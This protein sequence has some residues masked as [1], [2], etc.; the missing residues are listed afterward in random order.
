ML[1]ASGQRI[2]KL[3]AALMAEIGKL[4]SKPIPPAELDK[5]K[6]VL[7][8]ELLAKRETNEG[9]AYAL[10]DAWIGTGS[11]KTANT[12]LESL[13]A[14]T[15]ADVQRGDQD[16]ADRWQASES[17][18][19][20]RDDRRIRRQA[21]SRHP[22]QRLIVLLGFGLLTACGHSEAPAVSGDNSQLPAP[23]PTRA[24][25][26]A[27]PIEKQLANGLR[28]VVLPRAGSALVAAE[29]LLLSGSEVDPA[30]RAGLA[31]FTASLLTQ[32]HEIYN[33]QPQRQSACR[34]CRSA[35]RAAAGAGRLGC[36]DGRHHRDHTE[37]GR[38]ARSAGR[39]RP[40]SGRSRRMRWNAIAPRRSTACA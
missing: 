25:E 23:G 1:L 31:D 6:T 9:R 16:A 15:A 22:A 5:A 20:T 38:C 17:R 11:A 26:I 14:V 13:L 2:A 28:V 36:D 37:A 30:D 27:A 32:G 3:E 8:T 24:A 40:S 18:I 19:P 35:G 21:M 4:A 33:G 12:E 39:C 7:L 34:R 29:F 10:G